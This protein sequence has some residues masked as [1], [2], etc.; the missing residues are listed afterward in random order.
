MYLKLNKQFPVFDLNE[1][2]EKFTYSKSLN[3]LFLVN[4]NLDVF[5]YLAI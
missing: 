3:L 5:Y 4:I 1:C 2:N